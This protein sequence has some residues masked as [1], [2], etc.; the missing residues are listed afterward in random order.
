M[1]LR[2]DET[3]AYNLK[4]IRLKRKIT[5]QALA[6]ICG[7]SKQTISNIEKGQGATSKTIERL[8]ECLEISPLVFYQEPPK[9]ADI[10]FKRVSVENNNFNT[11]PYVIEWNNIA[12]SIVSD[13]TD[14]IF[15]QKVTPVIK[16][17]FKENQSIILN[18]LGVDKTAKTQQVLSS[19]EDTLITQV[20]HAIYGE[21]T[22]LDELI[23]DD[24]MD[25]LIE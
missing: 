20:K 25:E 22:D 4:A 7:I 24:D 2:I 15:Y 11:T 18:N 6:E 21:Q 12:N 17:V 8:A 3:V 13:T 14:I 5:Q 10:A 16:G 9:G 1:S 19:L 23:E